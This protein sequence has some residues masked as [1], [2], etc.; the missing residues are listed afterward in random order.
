MSDPTVSS[1][2]LSAPS[3]R[4]R[5]V[6]SSSSLPPPKV[7][8]NSSSSA[9]RDRDAMMNIAIPARRSL[10]VAVGQFQ[11]RPT[12]KEN[13]A[14]IVSF[15]ERAAKAGAQVVS[16]HETATTGYSADA[17]H[18]NGHKALTDSE[19]AIC[20]AC[21][22][23]GIAC[24]VGTA[25]FSE[26]HGNIKNTALVIDERG[27]CVCRQSKMQLVADDHWAV[28][29]T[30][31]CTFSLAGV[32]CC[33]IICHDIRHPELVRLCALKG[34]QVVFYIS[35]ETNLNDTS[36]ALTD[37]DTLSIYRAQVQ[38]RAVENNVWVIHANAA[39]NVTNRA[40]GSHGMSRIVA[41]TGHVMVEATCSEETLLTHKLDLQLSTRSFACESLRS[42]Y[43]LRDWYHSG[44]SNIVDASMPPESPVIGPGNM[45]SPRSSSP[46]HRSAFASSS[47]SS[48]GK[49][50]LSSNGGGGGGGGG[51]KSTRRI[52]S[53]G[54]TSAGTSP[55]QSPSLS[56]YKRRRVESLPTDYSSSDSDA[57]SRSN[58]V[59]SNMF[60]G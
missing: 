46:L 53:I 16:F 41:P 54:R 55:A 48:V 7:I 12:V 57:L 36:I 59:T 23:H 2:T 60:F 13:T 35:W 44:I 14:V 49:R 17:I 26:R 5:V 15:I 24:V 34:A 6:P 22:K 31:M 28:P 32:E 4:D 3:T 37:Q 56:M 42:N 50:R 29:G 47:S 40:L 20:S 11:S 18:T 30:Q 52:R 33:A 9:L 45:M 38:A 51:G 19:R 25:H 10:T 1:G 27:R 39:A 8:S 21:R 58:S 43:F